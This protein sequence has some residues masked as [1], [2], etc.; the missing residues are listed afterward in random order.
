LV[1]VGSS[2]ATNVALF[3]DHNHKSK[4]RHLLSS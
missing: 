2:S 1:I 4:F 3:L